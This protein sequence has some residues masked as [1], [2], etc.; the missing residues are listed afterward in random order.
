VWWT[1]PAYETGCV[2]TYGDEVCISGSLIAGWGVMECRDG[3]VIR[4]RG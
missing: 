3:R 2:A 4:L 1:I